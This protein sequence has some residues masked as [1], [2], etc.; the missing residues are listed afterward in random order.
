MMNFIVYR[1]VDDAAVY[2]V[3]TTIVIAWVILRIRNRGARRKRW[4][5]KNANDNN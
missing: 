2:A 4:N 3:L 1:T 5:S